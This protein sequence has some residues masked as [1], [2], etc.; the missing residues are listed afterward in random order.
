MLSMQTKALVG[1]EMPTTNGTDI[2]IHVY[3]PLHMAGQ[4]VRVSGQEITNLKDS[5]FKDL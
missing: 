1:L 3:V 5:F 4:A 2:S